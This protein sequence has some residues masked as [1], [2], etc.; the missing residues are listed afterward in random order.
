MYIITIN[1]FDRSAHTNLSDAEDQKQR[2]IQLG[3]IN[4][5][6]IQKDIF[7]PVFEE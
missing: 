1:G 6:I 4:I 3:E 7:N 2:F 5:E